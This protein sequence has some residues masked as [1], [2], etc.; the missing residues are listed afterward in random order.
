MTKNMM[1]CGVGGQGSL[2]ASR[3]LGQAALS[4]GWDTKVSE[5]HGMSQRGGSVVTY[6]RYSTNGRVASPVICKGEADVLISFEQLETA[7]W[8]P[9][10]K[11]NGKIITSTQKIYPMPVI[12]GNAEYPQNIIEEIEKLDVNISECDAIDVARKLGNE[13][14]ANVVLIGLYAKYS[15][16]DKQIFTD[17]VKACVP[18]KFLQLNLT[19][20]EAG[21]NY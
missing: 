9:F 11:K 17:A 8:L 7:R 6:V 21:Y 2:L 5:V 15:D 13:K 12:A 18:E 14:V 10:L 4:Q 19:A 1:I 3:I 16:L 20:F